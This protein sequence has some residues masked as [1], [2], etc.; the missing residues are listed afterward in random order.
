MRPQA[1][2]GHERKQPGE[3]HDAPLPFGVRRDE[4]ERLRAKAG[5]EGPTLCGEVGERMQH[6]TRRTQAEDYGLDE[7]RVHFAFQ[8]RALR[9]RP[10]L[11]ATR[12]GRSRTT[13]RR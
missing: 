13:P 9:A 5:A 2:C 6:A 12:R 7:V 8:F 1:T 11:Q 10:V 4:P 3:Q